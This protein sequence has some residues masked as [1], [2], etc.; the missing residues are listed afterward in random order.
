ML[1]D[2]AGN[3]EVVVFPETFAKHGSLIEADAMLLVR[4]KFEK[5]DESARL[6]ATELLPIAALKEKTTREIAIHLAVPPHGRSTFEALAELLARHRGDRKVF[7]ELDVKG[8]ETPLRVK[9]EV[10]Q[11]VKPSERLVNEVEQ[12]C[13]TGSVELR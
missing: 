4:G 11:R 3:V 2:I 13:G 10:A 12:L 5:D 9:S 6:V 8:R 7:L 1:D